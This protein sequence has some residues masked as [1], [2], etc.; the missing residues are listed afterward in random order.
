M[1]YN[2]PLISLHYQTNILCKRTFTTIWIAVQL[3]KLYNTSPWFVVE[4]PSN[5]LACLHS[6]RP[7]LSLT[8]ILPILSSALLVLGRLTRTGGRL[9]LRMGGCMCF[10]QLSVSL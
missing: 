9:T 5:I 8:P 4:S 10:L 2:E 3:G 7:P 6:H 1:Y